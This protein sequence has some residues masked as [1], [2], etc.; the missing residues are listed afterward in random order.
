MRDPSDAPGILRS[1]TNALLS[2]LLA[3]ACAVCDAILEEPLSGCVC[4][5]CWSSIRPITPPLCDACGDPLPRPRESPCSVGGH[6]VNTG[7]ICPRCSKHERIVHRSRAIG[8]YDGTLRDIIHALK[9]G[10]RRSLAPRLAAQMRARG[11]DLLDGADCVV[12]VPLHWRREHRRGFNQA[13]E[14]ARQLGLPVV[15]ALVRTRHTR[16]QVELPADRR[17][18]NVDRAF[19]LRPAWFGKARSISGLKAVL[20]DDVSTTGATLQACAHVLKRAGALEIYALTT[21]RVI[22]RR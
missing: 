3:P 5:T 13:R 17:R 19:G 21:A 20:V 12:P 4:R 6:N 14:L 1:T 22:A 15:D 9:Y 2:A 7:Q 10:H 18:G 16:P 8:E 11:M